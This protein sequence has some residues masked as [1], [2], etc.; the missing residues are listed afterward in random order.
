MVAPLGFRLGNIWHCRVRKDQQKEA[1]R[2]VLT[3]T[4]LSLRAD[5]FNPR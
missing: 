1:A 2:F 4:I 3:D 5:G